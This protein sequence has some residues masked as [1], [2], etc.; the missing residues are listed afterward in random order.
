M[1]ET[2]RLSLLERITWPF[3]FSMMLIVVIPFLWIYR[4]GPIATFYPEMLSLVC[5][6][7]WIFV[8]LKLGCFKVAIPRSSIYFFGVAIFWAIQARVM[9]LVYP[10]MSDMVAWA[11]VIFALGCWA[12]KG[13][14][15]R[16]GH[17]RALS[18]LAFALVI[19]CL[20][21]TVVMWLQYTGNA[22]YF[23]HYIAYYPGVIE[24]QLGQ[25]NHLGHY[26]MWGVLAIGWLWSQRRMS[27][28]LALLAMVYIAITMSLIGSRT[29]F[30]YLFALFIILPVWYLFAKASVKRLVG[31]L[32]SAVVIVFLFQ[33]AGGVLLSQFGGSVGSVTDRLIHVGF[34]GSGRSYEW[35]KAWQIF[36]SA[37]WFGHG[38]GSYSLQSFLTDIY[39]NGFRPYETN[40][41]FTHSHNVVLNLLAEMGIVGTI[42][43]FGGLLWVW[44]GGI[45]KQYALMSLFLTVLMSVS[46]VHSLFE[47]PL[48]Y[49]YFLSVFTLFI[50]LMPDSR[51]ELV[52][53]GFKLQRYLNGA[54]L[55]CSVLI[56]AGMI[57]LTLNYQIIRLVSDADVF[58][59]EHKEHHV[60]TLLDV[61]RN[62]PMLRFDAQLVLM[63]YF[64]P[65][66]HDLP[67]WIDEA[68]ESLRY[69]PFA[70]A[71]RLAL[72]ESRLGRVNEAREWMRWMYR[73][74]PS[75]IS[76]Y[77]DIIVDNP[78]Y[79][80][81]KEDYIAFCRENDAVLNQEDACLK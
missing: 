54:I 50:G 37:P 79:S 15:M 39:P 23:S 46:L 32:L 62:E 75:K 20:L 34:D 31:I 57:K 69:R 51:P 71:Y 38:W 49:M 56:L 21:Q 7:L 45:K 18:I 19:G 22:R 60:S 27:W 61:S 40:V 33:V 78:Y 41:L 25:R 30:A 17:E 64:D 2:N 42:L 11:F 70:S 9:H 12:A 80:D 5:M 6:L 67:D 44:I 65:Q 10:G 13:W 77:G 28:W 72:V 3:I 76:S 24:G 52:S 81:L 4:V 8:S 59:E 74:Y 43:V 48:W 47:Y 16:I 68:K 53:G 58:T 66:S 63:N 1:C 14:M 26:V 36:L 35:K 55:C 73:Y 29:I